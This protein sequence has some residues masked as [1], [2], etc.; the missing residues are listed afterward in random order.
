MA[1]N[2]GGGNSASLATEMHKLADGFRKRYGV[3]GDLT[4]ADMVKLITPP[5]GIMLLDAGSF[6]ITD[7]SGSNLTANGG[8]TILNNTLIPYKY[9]TSN[10]SLLD[11]PASRPNLNLKFHF[12]VISTDG[13]QINWKLQGSGYVATW[14]PNTE[15][16]STLTLPTGE[17]VDEHNG[18][19]FDSLSFSNGTVIDLS[20]SYLEIIK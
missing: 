10:K 1:Q 7:S 18:I 3:T 8:S 17:L 13:N 15:D 19:Q 20:K 9:Y 6:R 12:K 16:T 14:N 4:I 2:N 11:N 5:S